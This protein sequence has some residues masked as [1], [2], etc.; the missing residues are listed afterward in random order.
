[1]TFVIIREWVFLYLNVFHPYSIF[2]TFVAETTISESPEVAF[3][4]I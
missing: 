2:I 1:M 3:V 4:R